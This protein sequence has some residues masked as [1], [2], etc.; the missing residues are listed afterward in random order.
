[1]IGAPNF[2]GIHAIRVYNADGSLA[3]EQ[4]DNYAMGQGLGDVI[5]LPDSGLLHVG[6][7]D[8]CDYFGPDS[9]ISRFA[10]DGTLLWEQF[11]TPS[12]ASPPTMAAQGSTDQLAV[13]SPDFVYLLDQGGNTVGGFGMPSW[14]LQKILWAS[15][16]TLFLWVGTDLKLTDLQGNEWASTVI[17][18]NLRDM[19]WDGQ[20]LFVLADDS[21]RRYG[22]GLLPL[23]NHVLAGQ[24]GNSRFV[25]SDSGLYVNTAMGLYQLAD[26]G[27]PTLL[28][29]WPALPNMTNTGCAVRN[30]TVLTVGNTDISGRSTGI[31]RT[32]SMSGTAAQHDQDVEVLLQVDTAWT[33]FGGVSFYPWNRKADLTGLVVNHGSDTLRSVVLSMWLQVP[34]ILCDPYTNR[35]D[36][37]GFALAPGDTLNL[38]FGVVYVAQGLTQSQVVNATGEICIVALAPDQLADRAPDDN[39]AC[40]TAD[41]PLGIEGME[42]YAP[43]S[44]FPNPAADACTV[45]GLATLGA[46]VQL[47][48]LDLSG[49]T[50]S[51]RSANTSGN[52]LELNVSRLP[53]GTYFLR[54]EGHTGR[55][56]LKLA[57]TRP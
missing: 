32:L 55:A 25:P 39:T 35:I 13:A 46:P 22:P 31:V 45:S 26:D 14:S 11:I 20:Q 3:W 30:G 10:P 33:E 57:V 8:G 54:A 51:D 9:R 24:T 7:L 36:T 17:G 6:A 38:P 4:S 12:S 49:R 48:V 52:N 44:V 56:V 23:G 2:A 53:A 34:W 50:V 40:T 41:F 42:G 1:V 5:M 27:T 21:V 18:P 15:D 37:T 19:H 47:R 43:L 16:S 28:F 29:P